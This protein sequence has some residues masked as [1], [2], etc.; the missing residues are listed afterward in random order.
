MGRPF[1]GLFVAN[2]IGWLE[3]QQ[4]RDT[5]SLQAVYHFG[6]AKAV[7]LDGEASFA[8][9]AQATG[10]DEDRVERLIRHAMTNHI[11]TE[12]RTGYVAHTA[13]SR[14]LV[15]NQGLQDFVGTNTEEV[16]PASV[17]LITAMERFPDSK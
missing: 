9:I 7:P 5:L 16:W 17:S 13:A 14:L 6:M 12:P 3:A 10:V 8:Q 4:N 2:T 1:S 11:F 15:Q